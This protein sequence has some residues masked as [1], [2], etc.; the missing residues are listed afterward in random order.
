MPD[1]FIASISRDVIVVTGPDTETFL[2]GQ[3]SQDIVGLAVGDAGWSFV[4]QPQ[5]KVDAWV[6]VHRAGDGEVR[7]DVD[8]GFGEA[9]LARLERFKLRTR[10]DLTLDRAVGMLAVRHAPVATAL[11]SGWPDVVGGDVVGASPHDAARLGLDRDVLHYDSEAFAAER[12][13]AGVPAM[14]AE[15]TEDTIPAEIGQWIIDLSVSF[16]K[17]CFTGQEL[18]ARID[19]RG[20]N[21]PRHLRMFTTRDLPPGPGSAVTIDGRSVGVVTSSAVGAWGDSVGLALVHRS[22]TVPVEATVGDTRI[23]FAADRAKV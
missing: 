23:A 17:G 16:I 3:L 10:C 8:A 6:R 4:L 20:G 18:V 15:L 7:L 13:S 19:S 2:H 22:V 12:I 21:V 9:V 11:A 5:G 14:G 1:P